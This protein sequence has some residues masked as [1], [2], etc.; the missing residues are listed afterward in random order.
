[1]VFYYIK[2][3]GFYCFLLF[4]GCVNAMTPAV[5]AAEALA[6]IRQ[7]IGRSLQLSEYAYELVGP[8][9][10]ARDSEWQHLVALDKELGF[11]IRTNLFVE[12]RASDIQSVIERIHAQCI[13]YDR[14]IDRLERLVVIKAA[15]E[16]L[17]KI[18]KGMVA[19]SPQLLNVRDLDQNS[20]LHLAADSGALDDIQWLLGKYQEQ[21]A[22]IRE[23]VTLKNSDG[24][25]VI[26]CAH[27]Q[28]NSDIAGYLSSFILIPKPQSQQDW[29]CIL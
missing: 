28:G 5:T 21:G 8:Q 11:E 6:H 29:C 16:G 2:N 18:V 9:G 3:A 17:F 4:G 19:K 25:T 14:I 22:S 27:N 12:T 20:L 26:N 1:M 13:E 23:I 7:S 10:F 24:N 15:Q